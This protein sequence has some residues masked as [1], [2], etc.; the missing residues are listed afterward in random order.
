MFP[1]FDERS[2]LC[3]FGGRVL[4]DDEPKYLNSPETTRFSKRRLLFGLAQ[5]QRRRVRKTVY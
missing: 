5:A 4:N 2:R 1:V 3:G